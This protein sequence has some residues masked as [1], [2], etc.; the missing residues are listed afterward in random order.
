MNVRVRWTPGYSG[1]YDQVFAIHYRVKGSG[2]NFVEQ[3]VGH[4][5]NNRH[6]IQG[7]LPETDYEFTVQASNQA[8]KGAAST[9]KQVKTP[10][11]KKLISKFECSPF[12]YEMFLSA[13]VR[14]L[15]Q[16][17]QYHPTEEAVSLE[18]LKRIG[19]QLRKRS[20]SVR[21]PDFEIRKSRV[22]VPL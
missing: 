22:Q 2:A 4:P 3:S 6:T 19:L 15:F 9:S 21:A 1:G 16:S 14:S 12:I 5:Y 13:F 7:L 18:F 11:M 17:L 8:G 10:G 20:R